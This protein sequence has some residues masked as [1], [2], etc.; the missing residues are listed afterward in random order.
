M[1]RNEPHEEQHTKSLA[2]PTFPDTQKISFSP[3]R[4]HFPSTAAAARFPSPRDFCRSSGA[5]AASRRRQ[6]RRPSSWWQRSIHRRGSRGEDLGDAAVKSGGARAGGGRLTQLLLPA[7]MGIYFRSP[8]GPPPRATTAGDVRD[9]L[10]PVTNL[11][12]C[13]RPPI[14]PQQASPGELPLL[15]LQVVLLTNKL[16]FS[17]LLNWT[18]TNGGQ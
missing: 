2:L 16:F 1:P 3:P 18:C 6:G 12:S 5:G 8:P 9:L 7:S 14:H 15:V 17:Y 10:L 4:S 11:Y 13:R